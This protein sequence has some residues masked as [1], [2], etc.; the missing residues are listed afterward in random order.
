MKTTGST[1]GDFWRTALPR[2]IQI[3]IRLHY[4][5]LFLAACVILKVCFG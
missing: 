1:P 4:V 2:K 5:A 3:R